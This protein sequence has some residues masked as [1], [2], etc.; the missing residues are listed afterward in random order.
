MTLPKSGRDDR[1]SQPQGYHR[2]IRPQQSLMGTSTLTSVRGVVY[3]QP[4]EIHERVTIQKIY[5]IP[6]TPS[7]T[8]RFAIYD[9]NG[10]TPAGG[11]KLYDSGN[12]GA[13]TRTSATVNYVADPGLYWLAETT[14]TNTNVFTRGNA[15]NWTPFSSGSFSYR[16]GSLASNTIPLPDPC[17][18]VNMPIS[19]TAV[20]WL[21]TVA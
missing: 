16:A 12:I 21:L 17:P 1:R 10:D 3:F 6:S 5:L 7:G 19:T 18:A 13:A 4:F 15:Q 14:S 20:F 8:I 9:D 11:T 2:V